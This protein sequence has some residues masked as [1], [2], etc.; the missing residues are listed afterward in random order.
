VPPLR[1][2]TPAAGGGVKGP[3]GRF[4]YHAAEKR[5]SV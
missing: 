4:H 3:R 1:L 5:H 2:V